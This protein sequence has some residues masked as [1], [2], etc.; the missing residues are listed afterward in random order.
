MP[1]PYS[2]MPLVGAVVLVRVALYFAFMI[3]DGM[4]LPDR[5]GTATVTGK[6]Y[7]EAHQTYA[8]QPV[9]KTNLVRS[10]TVPEMYILKL[11]IHGKPTI[12]A[13]SKK[14]IYNAVRAGDAVEVTYQRR[15][16]HGCHPGARSAAAEN[17]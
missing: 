10:Q 14:S 9:G 6:E 12:A 5:M 8:T 2:F 13:R 11:E 4:W 15:R 7:R 1:Q 3:T 16:C 17:R